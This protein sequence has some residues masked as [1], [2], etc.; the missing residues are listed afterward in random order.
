MPRGKEKHS[1]AFVKGFTKSFQRHIALNLEHKNLLISILVEDLLP[2]I[3]KQIGDNIVGRMCQPLD[4]LV[5]TQFFEELKTTV[6]VLKIEFLQ[7]QKCGSRNNSKS[8]YPF[9]QSPNLPYSSQKACRYCERSGLREQ[10]SF[11]LTLAFFLGAFK[12]VSILPGLLQEP[13]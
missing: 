11:L 3:K 2:D 9:Y 7:E 6:F 13:M 1:E 8:T 4:I 5:A 12:D 10:K